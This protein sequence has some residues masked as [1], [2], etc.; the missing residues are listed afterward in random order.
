MGVADFY[1]VV[2]DRLKKARQEARLSRRDVVDEMMRRGYRLS[3]SSLQDL[4]EGR[5]LNLKVFLQLAEVLA[6]HPATLLGMGTPHDLSVD[7]LE[8]RVARSSQLSDLEKEFL[9]SALH[10]IR[11]LREAGGRQGPSVPLVDMSP[12]GIRSAVLRFV[13]Q[14]G[15]FSVKDLGGWEHFTSVPEAALHRE[16]LYLQ[17]TGLIQAVSARPIR[18]ALKSL[19]LE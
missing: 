19:G 14:G 11:R 3:V 1:Q 12:E 7:E 8:D 9:Y 2:G 10:H 17:R 4:E 18:Y 16:V 15:A 6:R 5:R 13:G